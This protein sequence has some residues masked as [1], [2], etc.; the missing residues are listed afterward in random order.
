M[1]V[2]S[3]TGLLVWS[4]LFSRRRRIQHDVQPEYSRPWGIIDQASREAGCP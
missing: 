3:Y 2:A 4:D 1:L